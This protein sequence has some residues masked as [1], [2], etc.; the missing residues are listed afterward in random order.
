[1]LS[2][3]SRISSKR[4]DATT[5]ERRL[6]LAKSH[7][8]SLPKA[9]GKRGRGVFYKKTGF[10]RTRQGR[11]DMTIVKDAKLGTEHVRFGVE[12]LYQPPLLWKQ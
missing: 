4:S 3:G 5:I 6:G 7:L 8:Y 12:V 10:L 1:M 9:F 11:R 2:S